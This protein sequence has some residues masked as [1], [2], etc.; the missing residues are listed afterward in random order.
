MNLAN[1]ADV[2][3]AM[4]YQGWFEGVIPDSWC[5][6]AVLK[7]ERVSAKSGEVAF[8]ATR[9]SAVADMRD[10]L[11]RFAPTLPS[12]VALKRVSSACS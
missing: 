8:Y 7:G 5:L 6:M 10:A 12:R 4:I 9:A 2:D 3:F 1:K 11:D